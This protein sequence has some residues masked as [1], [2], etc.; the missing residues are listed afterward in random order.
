V[1]G[2]PLD[3][4]CIV[5]ESDDVAASECCDFSCRLA[6]AAADVQYGHRIGDVDSV[7]KVML[8]AGQSLQERFGGSE[9][10]E[11]E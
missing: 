10:A 3:L 7:S 8:V 1:S 11:V 4:V 5:V 9:T 2:G 6:N